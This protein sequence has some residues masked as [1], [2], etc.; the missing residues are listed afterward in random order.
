MI[1]ACITVTRISYRRVHH[2]VSFRKVFA[3]DNAHFI[4]KSKQDSLEYLEVDKGRIQR[5]KCL[6]VALPRVHEGQ[7]RR[8]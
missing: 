5:W 2:I 1:V 4:L 8:G 7:G 6:E 3:T